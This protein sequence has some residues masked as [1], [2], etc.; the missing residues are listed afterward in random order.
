MGGNK[1]TIIPTGSKFFPAVAHFLFQ[2]GI[3]TWR[4]HLEMEAFFNSNKN[5]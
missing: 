3:T 2:L 1:E 4:G 5:F